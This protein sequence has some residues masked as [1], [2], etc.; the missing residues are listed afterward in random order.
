[1]R[2]NDPWGTRTRTE[3]ALT[4]WRPLQILPQ[5]VES[6]VDVAA[7]ATVDQYS[8][9]LD[10]EVRTLQSESGE[11]RLTRRK[12][13]VRLSTWTD[14]DGMWNVRGC[15]D[16]VTGVW[17]VSKIDNT[18][19]ALFAEQTPEHCP[20]DPIEKQ[21]FLAARALARLVEGNAGLGTAGRP[22][23]VAVIDATQPFDVTELL[24]AETPPECG[25][26]GPASKRF[27][28]DNPAGNSRGLRRC[29]RR[30]SGTA[31]R[32]NG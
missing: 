14:H 4:R 15:F 21:K 26:S 30:A 19:Q 27:H 8:K 13:N 28:R 24:D 6:L 2:Q 31:G 7:A 25:R 11:D 12:K 9:R 32:A 17:L 1:M 16:P 20:T 5:R 23:F 18:I 22:E 3:C 29:L 10:L